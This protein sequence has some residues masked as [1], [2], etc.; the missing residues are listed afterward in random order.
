MAQ[1]PVANARCQKIMNLLRFLMKTM[2]GSSLPPIVCRR[3]HV[4][5]T[6]FVFVSVYSGEHVE[7][8]NVAVPSLL[9][10]SLYCY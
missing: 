1:L 5:F 10:L 8:T 6:L 2:F 3:A 7:A 9:D 4:L